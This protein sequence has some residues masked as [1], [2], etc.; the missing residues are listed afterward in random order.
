MGKVLADSLIDMIDGIV[1]AHPDKFA[2][3]GTPQKLRTILKAGKISLPLGM[4]NGAPIGDV[5]RM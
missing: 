4:E 3:A 5:W 1:A 2:L